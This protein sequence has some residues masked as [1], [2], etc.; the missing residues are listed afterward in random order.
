MRQAVRGTRASV[1]CL[2]PGVI[3]V[4]CNLKVF[5]GEGCGISILGRFCGKRRAT[6]VIWLNRVSRLFD[7]RRGLRGF[8][9]YLFG[10]QRATGDVTVISNNYIKVPLN[11]YQVHHQVCRSSRRDGIF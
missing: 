9:A 8:Q 6:V 3:N 2:P 1:E 5:T 10:I 11:Y 4:E 7:E